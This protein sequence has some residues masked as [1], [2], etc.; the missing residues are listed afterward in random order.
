MLNKLKYAD[1][2]R[3]HTVE[4]VHQEISEKRCTEKVQGLPWAK[5]MLSCCK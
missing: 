4:Q 1:H 5:Y 2:L 3:V